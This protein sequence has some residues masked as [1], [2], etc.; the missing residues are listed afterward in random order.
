MPHEKRKVIIFNGRPLATW[1]GISLNIQLYDT[2]W[3]R[4]YMCNRKV[5]DN[6][7]YSSEAMQ[8]FINLIYIPFRTGT[9]SMKSF[10]RRYVTNPSNNLWSNSVIHINKHEWSGYEYIVIADNVWRFENRIKYW[11]Y[12]WNIPNNILIF[13]CMKPDNTLP[14]G[15]FQDLPKSI[16]AHSL[17]HI[18]FAGNVVLQDTNIVK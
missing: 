1:I 7:H 18:F 2:F 10:P 9:K 5:F 3:S 11:W 12:L 15:H 14:I 16:K 6:N 8:F 13:R 4:H 17:G